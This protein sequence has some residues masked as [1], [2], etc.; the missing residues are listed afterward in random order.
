MT[1]M[2]GS[3]PRTTKVIPIVGKVLIVEDDNHIRELLCICAR[4]YGYAV[5]EAQNG[6]Q[7]LQVLESV[8]DIDVV[9]TDVWMPGVSGVEL[10]DTL[11]RSYPH[12]PVALISGQVTVQ[13]SL[14]ALNMGA[15]AY[16]VKPFLPEQIRDVLARG[17]TESRQFKRVRELQSQLDTSKAQVQALHSF[18]S[19][20]KQEL[21]DFTLGGTKGINEGFSELIIGLRHELGNLTT[22]ILLNLSDMSIRTGSEES[23]LN[24]NLTDLQTSADDLAQLVNRL[25][26]FPHKDDTIEEFNM[27]EAVDQAIRSASQRYPLVEVDLK[28]QG[29]EHHIWG[30]FGQVTRGLTQIIENACR[31][32]DPQHPMVKVQI[33]RHESGTWEG[34]RPQ[35]QHMLGKEIVQVCIQDNGKGFAE[36]AIEAAFLPGYTTRITEGFVRGLGMGLFIA[37]ATAELYGGRTYAHNTP[38]SGAEVVMELPIAR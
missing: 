5:D 29:D 6:E 30:D 22:A 18:V 3:L 21:Q 17:L 33:T 24:E 34:Q 35:P 11:Q 27:R 37:R 15:Y 9:L 20:L 38:G 1:T 12:L 23:N 7:A 19:D 32:S 13:N 2:N 10:L 25:T 36:G 8:P 28:A 14:D 4:R 26:E 31:F 16:I